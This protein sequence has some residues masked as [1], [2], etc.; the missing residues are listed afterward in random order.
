MSFQGPVTLEKAALLN[1]AEELFELLHQFQ[2]T[3]QHPVTSVIQDGSQPFTQFNHYPHGDVDDVNTGYAW[4]Y[5]AHAPCDRRPWREHGHFHCYAYTEIVPDGFS[6]I[7]LPS[8]PDHSKGGLIHLIAL[9][10]N[11]TGVPCRLFTLN[12]WASDEWLYPADLVAQLAAGF[13]LEVP[14]HLLTS[15]WLAVMLRL[16]QPQINVLLAE[17]DHKIFPHYP[18][19]LVNRSED[20]ELEIT[21]TCEFDLD[22]YL[23]WILSTKEPIPRSS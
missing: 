16:L 5:H 22:Q 1:A 17:R 19:L 2:I 12:R 21:S 18:E 13:R 20:S 7:A 8:N 11:E 4:Y 14:R 10:M 23:A 9:S 3:G 6:P 15:R